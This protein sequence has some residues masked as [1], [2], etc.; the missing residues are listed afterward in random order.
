MNKTMLFALLQATLVL[1][2]AT[3]LAGS[4]KW[5]DQDGNTVYSQTRPPADA[6][7]VERVKEAPRPSQDAG[8][9][10]QKTQEQTKN[11]NERQQTRKTE[12]Q[13]KKTAEDK[14]AQRKQ[15]CERLNKNLE[16]LTTRPIVR[17]ESAEGE[18]VVLDAE[19]RE[20]E[21][22]QVRKLIKDAACI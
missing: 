17:K 21:V 8:E 16:V 1:L 14:E 4:Y 15:V 18:M 5:V 12:E 10:S 20:A 11:I 6:Q 9:A 3:T 7:N 19:Q 22:E 13:D 2:P